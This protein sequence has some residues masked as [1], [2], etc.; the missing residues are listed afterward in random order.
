MLRERKEWQE[1]RVN[2]CE[3]VSEGQRQSEIEGYGEREE[4]ERGR[5]SA[6]ASEIAAGVCSA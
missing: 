2:A 1:G 4:S 3:R 6:C 5:E